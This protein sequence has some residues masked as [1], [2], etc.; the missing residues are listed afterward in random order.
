MK[1]K[2]N[3]VKILYGLYGTY[4]WIKGDRLANIAADVV[5]IESRSLLQTRKN[6]IEMQ[7]TDK[8]ESSK[9]MLIK[10]RRLRA[11]R[12]RRATIRIAGF[13]CKQLGVF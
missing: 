9:E 6:A 11:A 2:N 4:R 3:N 13:A 8:Q 1:N 7:R 12:R 5:L 10:K